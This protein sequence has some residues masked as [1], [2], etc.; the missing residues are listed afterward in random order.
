MSYVF[1]PARIPC[2]SVAG[3]SKKFAVRR[4]Y[5]VGRNY[6][7]HAIEMG[8]RP[9]KEPPF[10]FSK[11]GT[12][13]VD[14]SQSNAKVPYPSAT[15]NFH[16]ECEYV[17]CIGSGGRDIS[18]DKALSYVF[19]YAVGVDLTRRDLQANAK[20]MKRP[21]D[22]SKGF[23]F[24]APMSCITRIDNIPSPEQQD[25]QLT[26]K[27]NG[28]TVQQSSLGEMIWSTADIVSYLSQLVELAPGDLIMTGT[29]AGVGPL[30]VGDVVLGRVDGL[31]P[32][33]FVVSPCLHESQAAL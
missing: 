27:V 26:L 21:W 5:C 2:L 14:A 13:V 29:P 25:G 9:D 1:P 11:P 15:S 24:S 32:V 12:A 8:A 16:Y 22:M 17:A 18:K 20:K 30:K 6:W 10:F 31:E 28:N 4:V 3:T 33:S 23:D 19:G 7:K